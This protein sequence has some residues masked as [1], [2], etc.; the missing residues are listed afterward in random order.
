MKKAI[1]PLISTMLL[2]AI[3]VA[4]A[5][6]MWVSQERIIKAEQTQTIGQGEEQVRCSYAGLFIRDCDYNSDGLYLTLKNSG[7]FNFTKP[8]QVKLI[9]GA[10]LIAPGGFDNDLNAGQEIIIDSRNFINANQ[11]QFRTEP[12]KSVRV[13]PG[14]CSNKYAEVDSCLV[15]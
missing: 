15:E 7:T 8:F 13:T 2:I 11:F 1:S 14:E 6:L 4:I 12:L 5:S 9:D 3:A 10:T